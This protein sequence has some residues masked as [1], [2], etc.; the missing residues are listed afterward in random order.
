[1]I[2]SDELALYS[3]FQERKTPP[4]NK[5]KTVNPEQDNTATAIDRF[6][7]FTLYK[8]NDVSYIA[9]HKYPVFVDCIEFFYCNFYIKAGG[10]VVGYYD[11]KHCKEEMEEALEAAYHF[12]DTISALSIEW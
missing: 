9:K 12:Q 1:M 8:N 4:R 7:N 11:W 6:E 5:E 10:P 2:D 3:G